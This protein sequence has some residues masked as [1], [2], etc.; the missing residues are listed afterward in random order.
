M[1]FSVIVPVY[2]VEKYIKKCLESVLNQDF[3]DYEIIVPEKYMDFKTEGNTQHNC[4]SRYYERAVEGKT[5]ILFIRKKVE[6]DKSFC[7][8]EIQNRDGAFAIIQ[9]RIAYNKEAPQEA[10]DFME[11]AVK[12]AQKTVEKMMRE[13]Q[14]ITVAV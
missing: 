13:K 10:K 2:N 1:K 8:V 4:V 3:D 11:K 12:E 5:I 9:N 14:K 6:P 7:T